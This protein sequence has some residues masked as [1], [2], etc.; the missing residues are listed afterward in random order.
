MTSTQSSY[1]P[2]CYSLPWLY[3][4]YSKYTAYQLLPMTSTQSSY[5]P[6]CYSLPW[7]YNT[8]SKYTA[9]KLLPM[10][11]TWVFWS[12]RFVIHSLDFIIPTVSIL[13][14][15]FYPI[16]KADD[17]VSHDRIHIYKLTSTN[18]NFSFSRLSISSASSFC[19]SS[20]NLS[21]SCRKYSLKTWNIN[22]IS[23]WSTLFAYISLVVIGL[24]ESIPSKSIFHFQWSI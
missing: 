5:H 4:S 24:N 18:L 23:S 19:F 14:T 1:H 17:K 10:I 3:N 9:Y 2:F 16:R 21:S 13:H 7:L 22:H 8:Y 12:P 6:F 20:N 11:S 15:N